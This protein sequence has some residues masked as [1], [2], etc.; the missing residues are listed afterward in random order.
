MSSPLPFH[1]SLLGKLLIPILLCGLFAITLSHL[2]I[3]T[4]IRTEAQQDA[5]ALAQ[6]TASFINGV[7][8]Y[9]TTQVMGRL[10]ID[11]D[12]E[13]LAAL[14]HPATMVHDLSLT[15]PRDDIS[16][17]LYSPYPF[18]N[19]QYRLLDSFAQQ[20]WDALVADPQLPYYAL[21]LDSAKAGIAKVAVAQRMESEVCVNCH[22]RSI[23]SPKH[24]WQQGDLVGILEISLPIPDTVGYGSQLAWQ[25]TLLLFVI[26]LLML[27]TLGLLIRNRIS[28]NLHQM[29]EATAAMQR[30]DFGL[31]I[32][33]KISDEF[34]VM[35]QQLNNTQQ[36]IGRMIATTNRT[37]S[38]V[39]MGDYSQRIDTRQQGQFKTL[40]TGINNAIAS[41]ERAENVILQDYQLLE[42]R[43]RERTLELESSNAKLHLA[44]IVYDNT[45]EAVMVT[46]P[47]ASII[48]VNNAFCSLTGY[49][50]EEA[51]GSKPSISKSGLHD[52]GFYQEM[53]ATLRAKGRWEGEVWDKR[54]NGAIY[55][56]WLS[57]N[58]VYDPKG[59]VSHYVAIFSD[60]SQQKETEEMLERLAFYDPLTALPN[61]TLFRDRLTHEIA[62]AR[63]SDTPLALMF[64]DLDRFKWVNDTL[65]HSAGDKLLKVVSERLQSC[66]RKSDTVARLGGD[67]FT[68]ILSRVTHPDLIHQI[69]Q[70]IIDHIGEAIPIQGKDVHVGVSI[71]IATFPADGNDIETLNRHADMAMY[72]A[73]GTG[74]NNYK[75]FSKE[76]ND[77]AFARIAMEEGL[78]HALEHHEFVLHYQPKFALHN[79]HLVGIEALVR[80]QHADG[81]LV[82]PADFI[83]LAEETGL[84]IPI[85]Q[86]I[87]KQACQQVVAWS[88]ALKHPIH[89]AVNLSMRQFLDHQLVHTISTTIIQSGIAPH[90]LELEL[91]ESMVAEHVS[92]AILT[93]QRLRDLGVNLAI[94]DFGTG[95][96]SLAYLKQFPL[97]T[98]KIDRSFIHDLTI[99]SNDT[100]IVDAIIAMGEGLHLTVVAEGVETEA[101]LNYLRSSGCHIAQGYLLAPPMDANAMWHFIESG[102]LPV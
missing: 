92:E 70:K 2:W 77:Q 38:R 57:I 26:L 89:L 84:I 52:S 11:L 24:D 7:R 32:E 81:E 96:S 31:L 27:L 101:Q 53:W 50:R 15:L 97:T 39:E 88:D 99:D 55:P 46:D 16:F 102:T 18:P 41:I 47:Q 17:R 42:E 98:L 5:I 68:I 66:V 69:A 79:N 90:Q 43:V 37:L 36:T 33:D 56:K 95:Y 65:G 83:P 86:W 34:G 93:M 73:K 12:S 23:N 14:P 25:I 60:I 30:G 6:T 49:S 35:I 61:R 75:F 48:D 20:A 40:A 44:G 87:L 82:Y 51:I 3:S 19:R 78:H 63:R 45:S 10:D 22:N 74:R 28:N 85:S 13:L 4:L 76:L 29:M 21:G 67:E 54:K 72:Q 9:Y 71:G 58:A 59:E 100:A 1:R 94:D 64:L 91:T 80:W 8:R 62:V